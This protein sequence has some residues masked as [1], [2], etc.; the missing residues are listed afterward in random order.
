MKRP[1]TFKEYEDEIMSNFD[2]TIDREVE[3]AIKGKTLYAQYSG[4]N[5]CGYVWWAG[6][7]HCEVWT[8]G[9]PDRVISADELEE[10]MTEVS[11]SY[12]YD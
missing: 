10:I 8:Y 9:S 7:W 11:G 3:K 12:G 5:F 2:H 1:D 4:W 6:K